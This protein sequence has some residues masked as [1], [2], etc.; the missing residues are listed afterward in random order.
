MSTIY[1]T[2]S[3]EVKFCDIPLYHLRPLYNLPKQKHTLLFSQRMSEARENCSTSA[4]STSSSTSSSA[5]SKI[6]ARQPANDPSPSVASAPERVLERLAEGLRQHPELLEQYVALSDRLNGLPENDPPL[7]D[8]PTAE[9]SLP[10]EQ[11]QPRPSKRDKLCTLKM[12]LE[13]RVELVEKVIETRA[14]RAWE[15]CMEKRPWLQPLE[16]WVVE[17]YKTRLRDMANNRGYSSD[18]EINSPKSK[19]KNGK[20]VRVKLFSLNSGNS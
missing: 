3:S 4:S 1:C 14:E 19:K 9:I 2:F 15:D 7:R 16:T 12:L 10:D 5:T 17:R 18:S 11:H 8:P 20:K 13:R 6:E